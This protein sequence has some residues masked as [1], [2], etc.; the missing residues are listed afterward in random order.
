MLALALLVWVV[1]ELLPLSSALPAAIGTG[2]AIRRMHGE[3]SALRSGW[4]D[5]IETTGSGAS[6]FVWEW[7]YGPVSTIALQPDWRG[8]A[9]DLSPV[10]CPGGKPQRIIFSAP[11]TRARRARLLSDSWQWYRI[12]LVWTHHASELVM[13]YRCVVVPADLHDGDPDTR[14][15][16]VEIAGLVGIPASG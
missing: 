8:V 6:T 1:A 3:L 15:L 16:A 5:D 4:T 9:L 10:T 2:S 13:T 11:G 14:P 7:S 12:G